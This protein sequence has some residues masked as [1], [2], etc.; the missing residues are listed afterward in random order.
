MEQVK[1]F[2]EMAPNPLEKKINE[3]LKEKGDSIVITS[4]KLTSPG[5]NGNVYLMIFYRDKKY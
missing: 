5:V 2:T 4:R 1:I 3:W